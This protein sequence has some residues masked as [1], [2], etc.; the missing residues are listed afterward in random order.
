MGRGDRRLCTALGIKPD[1]HIALYNKAC[2][3]GLQSQVE[4]AIENLEQAI[5]LSPKEYREMAK[6]DTDFAPIRDDPR[7]QG[8]VQYGEIA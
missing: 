2:C 8:L 7:F 4:L 1:Y 3:Y 5:H 6:T